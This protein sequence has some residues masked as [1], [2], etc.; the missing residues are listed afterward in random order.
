MLAAIV[1]QAVFMQQT[2]DMTSNVGLETI[3]SSFAHGNTKVGPARLYCANVKRMQRAVIAV[4]SL[5]A[6]STMSNNFQ[7]YRM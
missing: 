1:L 5:A 6:C 4:H 7:S 3:L 2:A